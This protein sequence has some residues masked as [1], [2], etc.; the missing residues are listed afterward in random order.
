MPASDVG[1][2]DAWLKIAAVP[3]P[4]IVGK[5]GN[6]AD[7]LA[8]VPGDPSAFRFKDAGPANGIVVRPLFDRTINAMPCIGA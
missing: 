8:P 6:P 7:W 1:D 3:V 5:S 4:A 2:K